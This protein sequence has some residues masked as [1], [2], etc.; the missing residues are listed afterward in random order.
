MPVPN[1]AAIEKHQV[2]AIKTW[3][4]PIAA[5]LDTSMQLDASMHP[6]CQLVEHIVTFTA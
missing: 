5:M 4:S 2:F 6:C 1:M 3:H